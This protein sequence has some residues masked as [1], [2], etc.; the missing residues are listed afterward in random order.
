M[1]APSNRLLFWVALILIPTALF[2]AIGPQTF[3]VG[4]L[5]SVLLVVA[6]LADLGV[7][8]QLLA[9]LEVDAP[10]VLRLSKRVTGS[11]NLRVRSGRSFASL[12]F[13]IALPDG[14]RSECE[15]FHMQLPDPC[16]W[17]RLSWDVIPS[18]CGKYHL[19]ACCMEVP[20]TLGFWLVRRRIET[21]SELRVYPD[22]RRERRAS[23]SL[24]LNRGDYGGHQFRQV[25]KGREFE[26]LREYIPGDTYQDIHWKTTAK[27]Q[28]PVTKVYQVERTQE[29]YVVLDSSRLSARRVQMPNSGESVT[30]LER[31][32]TSAMMLAVAAEAQG[33]LFGLVEFGSRP[34]LFL[35]ASRGKAHF[36][37]CR[38]ALYTLLPEEASPDFNE[39]VSFIR[40]RL[41]KRALIVFLTS[42]DDAAEAERFKENISILS[43][44]HLTVVNML[45]PASIAPLFSGEKAASVGELYNRLGGHVAWR[46]LHELELQLRAR[47]VQFNLCENEN[48]SAELITRYMQ[49]KQRQL[50]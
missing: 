1:I 29:V 49:I 23:A 40:T 46:K 32:I 7:S 48:L 9:G 26:Q 22:L 38:N 15:T 8:R 17:Y 6:V 2:A 16:T 19:G 45:R 39:V 47:G 35:K 50:I 11:I 3:A 42:L 14:I 4:V 13:G 27:R 28:H 18:E 41:R 5:L 34:N 30:L 36:D 24:F 12:R 21:E 25:S 37:T 44:H 20:S 43:R 31:Y 10:D 33:D